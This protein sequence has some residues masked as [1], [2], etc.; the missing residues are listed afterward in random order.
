MTLDE[1]SLP[2][3]DDDATTSDI[4]EVVDGVDRVDHHTAHA[5]K[6]ASRARELQ[7]KIAYLDALGTAKLAN[8]SNANSAWGPFLRSEYGDSCASMYT[9]SL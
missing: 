6:L 3:S 1:E 4:I 2:S 5:A 8:E 7:A 9:G